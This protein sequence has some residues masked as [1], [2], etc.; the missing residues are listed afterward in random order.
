MKHIAE[1]WHRRGSTMIFLRRRSF[2]IQL[3]FFRLA[4][5]KVKRRN[6]FAR[7]ENKNIFDGRTRPITFR[8]RELCLRASGF[9]ITIAKLS[10]AVPLYIIYSQYVFR[11]ALDRSKFLN[12]AGGQLF[13]SRPKAY[14][15]SRSSSFEDLCVYGL[16]SKKIFPRGRALA[17]RLYIARAQFLAECAYRYIL[18]ASPSSPAHTLVAVY[19]LRKAIKLWKM[20]WNSRAEGRVYSTCYMLKSGA[21]SLWYNPLSKGHEEPAIRNT[22]IYSA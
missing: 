13:Y 22:G 10:A 18:S 17:Q 5:P 21:H 11:A 7:D 6:R 12:P 16:L 19:I 1:L 8:M 4:E 20:Y 9:Q 3:K 15:Y 2:L 14:P